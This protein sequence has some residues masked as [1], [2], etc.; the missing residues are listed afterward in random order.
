MRVRVLLPLPCRRGL[1]IVRDDFSFAKPSARLRRRTCFP[2]K[3]TLAAAVC[4]QARLRRLSGAANLLR[5]QVS[6]KS[7]AAIFFA[8]SFHVGASGISLAPFFKTERPYTLQPSFAPRLPAKLPGSIGASYGAS[9]AGASPRR[10]ESASEN[11]FT[12]PG[13]KQPGIPGPQQ[14]KTF[15]TKKK[16]IL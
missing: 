15:L 9:C 16:A 5:G 1:C 8:S 14:A 10:G 13:S 4:L 6:I 11:R 3:V 12:V 7:L 2:Q